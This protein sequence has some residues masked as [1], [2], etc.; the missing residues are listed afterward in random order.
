MRLEGQPEFRRSPEHSAEQKG[1]LCGD[2]ALALGQAP[3]PAVRETRCAGKA[4]AAHVVRGEKL[5]LEDFPRV[6][7][8]TGG[9]SGC[10]AGSAF[11]ERGR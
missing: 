1:G 2:A 4:R 3:E 7:R 11:R 6:D 9:R 5:R 10:H 8:R